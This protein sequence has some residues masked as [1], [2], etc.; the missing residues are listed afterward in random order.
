MQDYLVA[1][2]IKIVNGPQSLVFRCEKTG[3]EL[4]SIFA[5]Q[6]ISVKASGRI[7]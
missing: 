1:P 4:F 6:G 3:Y 5:L 2:V 7:I